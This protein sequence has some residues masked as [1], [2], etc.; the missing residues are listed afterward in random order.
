MAV[1]KV[2]SR[3]DLLLFGLALPV[4]FGVVGFVIG[5]RAHSAVA[6]R[7]TWCVG[8]LFALVY[9]VRPSLQRSIYGAWTRA[10]YPI[11]WLITHTLVTLVFLLVVCPIALLV[12]AFSLDLLSLRWDAESSSYW[13]KRTKKPTEESYLKQF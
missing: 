7:V 3:R 13:N 8:A 12:R 1:D 2:P 10:T 4:L 9:F 6:S 5:T 11:G